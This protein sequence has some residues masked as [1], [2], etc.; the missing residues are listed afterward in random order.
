MT[1]LSAIMGQVLPQ[2]IS[3]Q[4]TEI[5]AS[6]LFVAFGIKLGLESLKMTGNECLEELDEVTAELGDSGKKLEE[7]TSSDDARG[8]SRIAN[9]WVQTFVMTFLAEW[10][11][12]SQIATVALSGANNFLWVTIG[13]LL[14]HALCTGVAV[15]GGRMV[16]HK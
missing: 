11:D 3:K 10:G 1:I 7:G 14:G 16:N 12:R 5:A 2:L 13:G 9:I 15:V 8:L 6:V 4:Y